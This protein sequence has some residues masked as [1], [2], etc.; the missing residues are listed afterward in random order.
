MRHYAGQ[1]R[2][3]R[4]FLVGTQNESEVKFAKMRSASPTFETVPE[5]TS[6]HR[7][8][9]PLHDVAS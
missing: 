7:T 1:K 4:R 9:E 3:L 8:T 6:Q 5:A 2:R